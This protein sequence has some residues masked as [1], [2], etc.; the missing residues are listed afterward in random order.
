MS[1]VDVEGSHNCFLTPTHHHF[2]EKPLDMSK[3]ITIHKFYIP[4]FLD[5]GFD[6]QDALLHGPAIL[7]QITQL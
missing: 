1:A 5:L 3:S 2:S 7:V 6:I 4:F